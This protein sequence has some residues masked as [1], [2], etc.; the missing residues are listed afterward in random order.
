MNP[1][2]M[3]LCTDRTAMCKDQCMNGGP[4]HGRKPLALFLIG[5]GYRKRIHPELFFM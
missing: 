2:D 5:V 3:G 4:T 1:G